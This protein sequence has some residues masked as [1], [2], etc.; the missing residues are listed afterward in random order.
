MS[1]YKHLNLGPVLLTAASVGDIQFLQALMDAGVRV[2]CT[3]DKGETPLFQAAR[4]GHVQCLDA[5]IQRGAVVN[6]LNRRGESALMKTVKR[7]FKECFQLLLQAGADV[8]VLSKPGKTALIL[9]AKY[10]QLELLRAVLDCGANINLR[11]T[12]PFATLRSGEKDDCGGSA[13]HFALMYGA[14]EC[15]QVL[16]DAGIDV[17]LDNNIGESA[18]CQAM[19][20]KSKKWTDVLMEAG[21]NVD[22]ETAFHNA[23]ISGFVYGVERLIDSGVNVNARVNLKRYTGLMLATQEGNTEVVALLLKAGANVHLVEEVGFTALYWAVQKNAVNCLRLLLQADAKINLSSSFY[24]MP[25]IGCVVSHAKPAVIKVLHAAGEAVVRR[26]C[27]KRQWKRLDFLARGPDRLRL[28]HQREAIR[29]HLLH[30]DFHEN[31]IVRIPKLDV[32]HLNCFFVRRTP[33]AESVQ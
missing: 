7:G 1:V 26:C 19:S 30:M 18:L 14:D 13:L 23:C 2:D 9:A 10:K 6:Q 32:P 31:L 15:A 27:N 28:D 5:L 8:N 33:I 12:K 16:L 24:R 22:R 4:G 29:A 25:A 11:R 20:D 3:D 21:C 17:N